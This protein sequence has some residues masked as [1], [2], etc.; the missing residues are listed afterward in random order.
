MPDETFADE[1]VHDM[2]RKLSFPA[3]FKNRPPLADDELQII[4]KKLRTEGTAPAV[5]ELPP[6]EKI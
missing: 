3:D 4:R 6:Q 1:I 2:R 5:I